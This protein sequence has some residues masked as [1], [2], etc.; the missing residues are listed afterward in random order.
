PRGGELRE[1][2]LRVLVGA[3]LAP[4]RREHAQLGERGRA[5]EDALDPLVLL[6]RQLVPADQLGRDGGVARERGRAGRRGGRAHTS[7]ALA[8][9]TP[10]ITAR[11]TRLMMLGEG[12]AISASA[13]P[14]SNHRPWQC[15]HW[16]IW[17]PCHSPVMRS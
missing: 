6:L 17:M 12:C 10:R 11:N 15:V 3:V 5:A 7:V 4:Q 9:L 13:S 16:S 14:A 2:G 1:H 8:P